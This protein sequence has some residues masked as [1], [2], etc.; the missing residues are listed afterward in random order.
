LLALA[1][2]AGVAAETAVACRKACRK[3]IA[4]CAALRA[5]LKPKKAKRI[6]WQEL[7]PTCRT[8]GTIECE[9]APH[10]RGVYRFVGTRTAN[11]CG[12]LPDYLLAS[13]TSADVIVLKRF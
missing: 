8:E 6:C 1:T 9:R 12:E 5:P 13:P 10:Y 2:P 7:V 4:E 3:P 11:T